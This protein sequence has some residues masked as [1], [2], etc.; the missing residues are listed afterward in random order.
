MENFLGA[1]RRNFAVTHPSLSVGARGTN[2]R[3]L[4]DLGKWCGTKPVARGKLGHP[5]VG[6]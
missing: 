5:L 1:A 2:S 6:P 4:D 3:F